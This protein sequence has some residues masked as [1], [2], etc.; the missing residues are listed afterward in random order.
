MKFFIGSYLADE[1]GNLYSTKYNKL[2]KLKFYINR[3]GYKMFRVCIN[4]KVKAYSAHHISYYVNV[5]EFDTKDGLVID[6]ID[7]NKSNNHY[8]NLR[9]VSHKENCNNEKTKVYGIPPVNKCDIDLNKLSELKAKG[10]N[11]TQLSKFFKCSRSTV[12][13]RLSLL[14]NVSCP[15]GQVV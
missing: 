1:C 13:G 11:V 4:G 10:C 3:K 14:T 2:H 8:I 15:S 5:C 7:G 6:H 12:R 9:R